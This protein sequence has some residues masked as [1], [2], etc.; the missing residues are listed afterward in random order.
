MKW[1]LYLVTDPDQSLGR[2]HY[3]V[4]SQAISGGIDA[5]L[6]F[7]PK[8]SR[9]QYVETAQALAELTSGAG[10]SFLVSEAADVAASVKADGVHLGGG[11]VSV[12]QARQTLGHKKIVGVTVRNPE[13]AVRAEDEGA[14]YVSVGNIF[15][16]SVNLPGSQVVGPQ[17]IAAVK[18]A[19]AIP[20]LAIGGI[21][22]TNVREVL[23]QGADG[24]AVVSAVLAKW[25][26]PAA[27]R[28]LRFAIESAYS[29]RHDPPESAK[30][31]P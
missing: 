3:D 22:A 8:M 17:A 26:I 12:R 29:P 1:D 23:T 19:V 24:V 6:F 9:Q 25:D 10:V 27:V 31:E 28:E 18:K 14:D 13:E 2:S 20:V 30:P 16:P 15:H 21:D 11:G 5:V 4:V 7:D